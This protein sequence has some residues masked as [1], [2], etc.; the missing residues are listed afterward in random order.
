M[1]ISDSR[2]FIFIH[3]YK[4]AGTS[5]ANALAPFSLSRWRL[6]CTRVLWRF[7]VDTN[8]DHPP[9]HGHITASDLIEAIGRRKFDSYFS[10]AFV[11]NPWAWQVSLYTYMMKEPD[12]Y[13]HQLVRDL[14]SF[15]NYIRWR[16]AQKLRLQRD[17]VCA[18]DNEVLVA[19]VGRFERLHADFHTV[20]SRI[21][22]SVSLPKLNVSNAVP[23]Q[24]F[25]N[26]ETRE[27]VRQI[28]EAD[29]ELFGY[30]F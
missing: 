22:V 7:N 2:K 10:F 23:Y 21:G 11:R 1:L 13:Q 8:I 25:Y 6:L 19:Y 29:V 4:N 18:E 20:C 28:F 16:C 30:K 12:H 9:Y 15:D 17:F 5:I 27:L 3:I 14:G 26:Q 24:Q